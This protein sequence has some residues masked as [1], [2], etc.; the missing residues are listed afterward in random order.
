MRWCSLGLIE[1]LTRGF[2]LSASQHFCV[3]LLNAG[4][5]AKSLKRRPHHI[6]ATRHT[7]WL[8]CIF[9]KKTGPCE[10]GFYV[11]ISNG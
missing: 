6:P 4:H 1:K 10:A 2:H 11:F 3:L 9:Q 8:K 7:S 5:E